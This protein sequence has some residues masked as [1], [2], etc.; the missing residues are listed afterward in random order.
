MTPSWFNRE[1]SE[2]PVFLQPNLS[3][4]SSTNQ[5]AATA[6]YVLNFVAIFSTTLP[7]PYSPPQILLS[8]LSSLPSLPVFISSPPPWRFFDSPIPFTY[9]RWLDRSHHWRVVFSLLYQGRL[10]FLHAEY[11]VYQSLEFDFFA[12]AQ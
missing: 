11:S 7:R 1:D 9:F 3:S 4:P 10:P 12:F 2:E 8:S 5:W 6:F